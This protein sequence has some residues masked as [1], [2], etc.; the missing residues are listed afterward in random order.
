MKFAQS[1]FHLPL[2][3][4]SSACLILSCS[5]DPASSMNESETS[6]ELSREEAEE[7]IID[8]LETKGIFTSPGASKSV[9]L[10][11]YESPANAKDYVSSELTE[12]GNIAVQ[13]WLDPDEELDNLKTNSSNL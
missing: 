8:Y 4:L 2:L 5:D 1:R 9:S 13:I 11:Q 7:A 3:L 10:M 12:E 6:E